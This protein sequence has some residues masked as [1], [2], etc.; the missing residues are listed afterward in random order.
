M[1]YQFD[2]DLHGAVLTHTVVELLES[3]VIVVLFNLVAFYSGE[4]PKNLNDQ[5]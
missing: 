3:I 2:G 1:L 5:N 4:R